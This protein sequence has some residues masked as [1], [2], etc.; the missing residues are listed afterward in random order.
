MKYD[1]ILSGVGGQGVLSLAAVI[2]TAAADA[3]YAVRQSEVHGMAQRGG[4]VMAHMRISDGEIYSDLIAQGCADMVLSMEPMESLRYT[5]W[6]SKDGVLVTARSPFVNIP[7]YPDEQQ[8]YSAIE[9]LPK[10]CIVDDKELAKEAG[11][12]KAGNMVMIGAAE[13]YLPLSMDDLKGAAEKLFAKK[14][15]KVVEVNFKA[16]ELGSKS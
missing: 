7:N 1:I 11:S 2:A 5:G 14:G 16:L 3:G 4:A 9:A 13:A 8:I 10:S 12:A 6:L 15:E